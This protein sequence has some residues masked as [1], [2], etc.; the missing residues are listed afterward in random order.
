MNWTPQQRLYAAVSGNIPD[1]VPTLPKIWIDLAARLTGTEPRSVIEDPA[2]MM[3]TVIEAC[4]DVDADAAR[5]F[6]IPARKTQWDNGQLIEVD[7]NGRRVGTIDLAGGWATH[8]DGAGDFDIENPHHVAFRTFRKHE[9]PRI[10][11]LDGAR[12]IAV[13]GPSFWSEQFAAAI[14]AARQ[15]AGGRIALIG[16]CDSATLAWYIEFRGMQ[17]ALADLIEHP[18]LVHAVM[19]RGVEYAVGR[20]RFFIDQGLSI[21]RL[22]DSVANMSVISPR[23]WREFVLPHMKTV[24]RELHAH[25]PDVRI[26]CHICGNVLPVVGDILEA[27]IDCIGPLDPLGGFTCAEI[28]A[29]VGDGVPLMGGVNTLS[30]VQSTPQELVE[31][32]RACIEAA[33]ST[34]PYVLGSGCA[35][36]AAS[37]RENLLA[38]SRAAKEFGA[39]ASGR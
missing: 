24:C 29:A 34:G 36:P 33:G 3:S 12:R 39:Y 22:N 2:L 17:R 37:K 8:L 30:F 19:E 1:R 14:G 35:L 26:Y 7:A 6:F 28:R 23:H 38:L 18:K 20:G 21:L 16:D 25:S 15:R 9:A 11:D 5:L 32:A 4:V 13:P 10:T 31:E 27:G